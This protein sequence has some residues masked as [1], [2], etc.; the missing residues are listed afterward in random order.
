M[1][2]IPLI[3]AAAAVIAAIASGTNLWWQRGD[4][5]DRF[6]LSWGGKEAQ[7][8]PGTYLYV[9]NTGKHDI[10]M[11]DYGFGSTSGKEKLYSIPYE[12]VESLGENI[13]YKIFGVIPPR[14]Q[15]EAGADISG[16]WDYAYAYTTTQ[17]FP[18]LAFR[19][20]VPWIT[21]LKL[22]LLV[23]FIGMSALHRR[24]ARVSIEL[25]RSTKRSDVS[26][27][28]P[29]SEKYSE[30]RPELQKARSAFND[31]RFQQLNNLL[32]GH[33]E[34]SI[35]YLLAVNGGG[36]VAMLG[37]VG[38]V[39]KWRMQNWPYWVLAIFVL[40]L[41]LAGLGRTVL[42]IHT[43]HLLSGWIKDTKA[44]FEDSLDWGN[45][46]AADKRRVQRMK[47][48]PW[49]IGLLSF[50]CFIGGTSAAGYLFATL[51]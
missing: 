9:V 11:L 6:Y 18:Q 45:V 29:I 7:I 5:R 32:I 27:E 16:D 36:C 31:Q 40:G 10:E 48:I 12:A 19:D 13:H 30:A 35:Q 28:L 22:R 15:P 21:R 4:R 25:Q 1:E 41:V 42:L 50:A 47:P 17:R 24:T 23:R 43:Q 46:V 44:H 8:E 51:R 2:W 26:E 20:Q 33:S 38:A 37:L 39:E 34:G 14:T 3:G 49:V